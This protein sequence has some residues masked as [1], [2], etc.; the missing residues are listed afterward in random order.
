VLVLTTGQES[1]SHLQRS[2]SRAARLIEI[3]EANGI[4]RPSQRS[5]PREIIATADDE[6]DLKSGA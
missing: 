2:Y 1:A 5:K 4:V 3:M 6:Q